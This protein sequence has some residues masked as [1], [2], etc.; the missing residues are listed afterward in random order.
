MWTNQ[1]APAEANKGILVNL[2]INIRVL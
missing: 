1:V 2:K